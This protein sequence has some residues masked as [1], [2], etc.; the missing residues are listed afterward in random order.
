MNTY[1]GEAG[2]ALQ[3]LVEAQNFS[4]FSLKVNG[5]DILICNISTF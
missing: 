3:W 4:T 1:L 5:N 2:N